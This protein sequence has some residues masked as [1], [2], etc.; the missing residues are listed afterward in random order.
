MISIRFRSTV[1]AVRSFLAGSARCSRCSRGVSLLHAPPPAPGSRHLKAL[2]DAYEHESVEELAAVPHDYCYHFPE[3]DLS[4][5]GWLEGIHARRGVAEAAGV[6]RRSR[7]SGL[8]Y[9][10]QAGFDPDHSGLS[11]ALPS[12]IAHRDEAPRGHR[13]GRQGR[14]HREPAGAARVLPGAV[15]RRSPGDWGR[16]GIR[17]WYVQAWLERTS[18]PA[19]SLPPSR[20]IVKR[21]RSSFTLRRRAHSPSTRDQSPAPVTVM[22][23]CDLPV[24]R[25][26]SSRCSIRGLWRVAQRTLQLTGAERRWSRPARHASAPGLLRAALS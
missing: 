11:F 13:A 5:A 14:D 12:R 17:R 10:V 16:R 24:P 22:V 21:R 23:M 26:R 7:R 25:R 8:V 15:Y 1:A 9:P 19:S 2:V 4:G 18:I 20:A 6:F 3:Q